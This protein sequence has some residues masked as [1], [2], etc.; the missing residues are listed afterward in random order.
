VRTIARAPV[1]ATASAVRRRDGRLTDA[2]GSEIND[3]SYVLESFQQIE[4]LTDFNEQIKIAIPV[5]D[6]GTLT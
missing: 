1:R 3:I 2:A 5:T 4:R 6:T